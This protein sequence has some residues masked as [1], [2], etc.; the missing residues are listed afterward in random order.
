MNEVK[1]INLVFF[2]TVMIYIFGSYINGMIGAKGGNIFLKMLVSQI[3]IT[4]PSLI[5]IIKSRLDTV[6]VIRFKKIDRLSII[7][8]ILFAYLMI[9]IMGMI[10]MISQLFATN[11]IGDSVSEVV[12]N[13]PLI[14]SL[15]V[16][17]FIP[18]ILEEAVYR[19]VI[20]NGYRKVNAL[21]G[22]FL[23]GL[24]FGLLHMN[25]NQFSYAF[26]M[27]VVFAL[28][29][30]ATDSIVSSMIVHFVINGTSVILA[31]LMPTIQK[32]TPGIN[33]DAVNIDANEVL[34]KEIL[35]SSI[36]STA[37]FAIITTIFAVIIFV[38][39]AK[40]SKRIEHVKS[41]FKKSKREELIIDDGFGESIYISG[42]VEERGSLLSAPLVVV[43]IICFGFMI[44]SEL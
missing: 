29:I 40:R 22:I 28:L 18:C 30:E 37:I 35:L 15:F 8:I 5:Y 9:P 32:I 10:N 43:M 33:G 26:I 2:W 6:K 38:N 11:V 31:Y 20:Y 17:A 3:L 27:G 44:I 14:L 7:L 39:I 36:K 4:I 19:G 16:I 12:L 21:K 13:N 25:F 41:I 42:N 23:S 24:L 1:K 34:T